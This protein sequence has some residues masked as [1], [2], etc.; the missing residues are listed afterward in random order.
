M[1]IPLQYILS[2]KVHSQKGTKPLSNPILY[3]IIMQI[4]LLSVIW[5]YSQAMALAFLIQASLAIILLEYVNYLQHYGL[6][7]EVGERQTSMHSW[8]HRGAWSRW[9]LLEL[10]LHPSHHLKASIPMWDLRAEKGS[11]QL[12]AGYYACFWLAVVPPLWK[13]VMGKRLD[14]IQNRSS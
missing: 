12:P 11:P 14:E 5:W 13:R 3:G 8:E 2:W 10:P 4:T 7:R 9:T 1:T 6:R